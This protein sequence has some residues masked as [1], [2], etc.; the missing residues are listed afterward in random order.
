M[1]RRAESYG[2]SC[3]ALDPEYAGAIHVVAHMMMRGA[4]M[5][6]SHS[7]PRPKQYGPGTRFLHLAWHRALFYPE[8]AI[9]SP[10]VT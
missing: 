3:L 5:M 4:P 10:L 1:Y 9:S 6:A 7:S 8:R 2:A